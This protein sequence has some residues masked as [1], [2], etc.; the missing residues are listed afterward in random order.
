MARQATAP[1]SRSALC[2]ASPLPTG[3][4]T[5]STRT[6]SATRIPAGPTPTTWP[7]TSPS[8]R[9]TAPEPA[10]GLDSAGRSGWRQQ[11]HRPGPLHGR[12]AGPG[13]ELGVDVA[14]VGVDRVDRDRKLAGDLGPG[15][16]SRQ[17]SQHPQL[18]GA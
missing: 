7:A 5:G 14:D 16:V 12:G 17:V 8:V 6:S 13:L 18:A 9:P 2:A 1:G 3:A 4:T 15:E 10:G 11:P